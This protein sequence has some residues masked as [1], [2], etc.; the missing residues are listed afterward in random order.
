MKLS[1]VI[2]IYNA[3]R[4]LKRCIESTINNDEEEI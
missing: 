1:I 2:P 4:Y 3:E